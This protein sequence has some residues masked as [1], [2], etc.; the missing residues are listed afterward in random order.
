[1]FHNVACVFV[2]TH[3]DPKRVDVQKVFIAQGPEALDFMGPVTLLGNGTGFVS[4][5]SIFLPSANDSETWCV[6]YKQCSLVN[7]VLL[8]M[9][10]DVG[11]EAV[12]AQVL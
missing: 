6:H 3:A 2:R 9:L 12:H 7:A 8:R 11:C 10:H 1:M 4:R 5:M